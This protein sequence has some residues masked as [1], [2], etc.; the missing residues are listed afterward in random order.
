MGK[1]YE[2]RPG[3]RFFI[4]EAFTV[5][6]EL[7]T[8]LPAATQRFFVEVDSSNP[9]DIVGVE[10]C[11]VSPT[12]DATYHASAVLLNSCPTG[13][14]DTRFR[15]ERLPNAVRLS[16]RKFVY[17]SQDLIYLTCTVRRCLLEPCGVCNGR[18]LGE[19]R[20]RE[21]R[22][23]HDVSEGKDDEV[24]VSTQL[25]LRTNPGL[26]ELVIPVPGPTPAP[27]TVP[28]PTPAPATAPS[29]ENT[30]TENEVTTD[31]D[32]PRAPVRCL[33]WLIFFSAVVGTTARV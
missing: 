1:S 33:S 9:D 24:T 10:N 20:P 31:A 8:L 23:L 27:A 29:P 14:F 3:L 15:E 18:R 12:A 32:V 17:P 16:F 13:A 7:G 6:L 21:E 19:P 26:H 30:P 4:D 22:R 5:L 25:R 2:F 11:S 28:G